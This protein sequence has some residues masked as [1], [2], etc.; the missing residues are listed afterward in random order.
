MALHKITIRLLS[1][2]I[3]PLKGD[4]VWGH[5]VWGIA[6]NE[7]DEAV[8][9]FLG[10]QKQNPEIVVSS[11]FPKGYICRPLPLP[12]ERVEKLNA[13]K[14]TEIKKEKK[15]CFIEACDYL[16]GVSKPEVAL[17]TMPLQTDIVTHNKIDRE[18][19]GVVE[20]G[21]YAVEQKWTK[22]GEF[23]NTKINMNEFD[24]YTESSLSAERLEQLF[25]WA[26][27]NGYG[28]D[29][30]TGKGKIEVIENSIAKVTPKFN[31]NTYVALAPFVNSEKIKM[32][33]LRADIFTRSGRLGGGFGG[34]LSPFKKTVVLFDEGAVFD[35]AEKISYCGKLLENV[36][37]DKRICQAGFA[38]VIP[39]KETENKT[40]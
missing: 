19:G 25:K 8:T 28:A 32:A 5:I 36:H 24:I 11:A 21:L 35:C 37:S 31:T 3:T 27:E 14:Y 30:S 34:S 6:N 38:P 29:A 39:I 16:N 33:N 2:F 23:E 22:Y 18:T 13:S 4:T 17:E 9:A 7:G 1:P 40:V 12:K 26:F 20:G 10:R 15:R